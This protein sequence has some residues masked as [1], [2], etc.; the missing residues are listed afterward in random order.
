M[1][2]PDVLGMSVDAAVESI[3]SHGLLVHV[4]YTRPPFPTST[5]VARIVRMDAVKIDTVFLTAAYQVAIK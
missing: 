1:N 2:I 5:E 3:R 4:Q